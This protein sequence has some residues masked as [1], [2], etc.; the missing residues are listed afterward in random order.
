MSDA[1]AI[2]IIGMSCSFA[3]SPNTDAFWRTI[4]DGNAHFREVPANR[5]DHSTFYSPNPRHGDMTYARKLAFL[6]DIR[7]FAP[8][9][10]GIPPKRAHLMDPQ[11]RLFLDQTRQA[12]DD[13]GYGIRALPRSTGV[14]VGASVSEY[15]D[16]IVSRLR[17]R[18]ILGGQWGHKPALSEISVSEVVQDIAAMQQ[19]SMI[20]GLLNMIACNVSEAFDLQGPA[21]V[22]D[23]ACSSSLVALQEAVLHL[24]ERICDAAIVGGVHSICSPDMMV[25]FSKIGALSRH[26]ICRPFDSAADGF[27]L[28]E[29]VGAVILKRL[30]DAVRDHDHIRAVIRG[31]GLNNDGRGDGPMTPRVDGQLGA[32]AR[33]FQDA[34]ISPET[35]SYVEA[36]GTAT[37]VGDTTEISALK[38]NR[39]ANNHHSVNCG[40]G[41]VKGNIG[42][43]LAA[44]GI[45][46]IIKA[47]L[48][49]E[50][51]QIPP[52]AGLQTPRGALQLDGSG[53]YVPS[54]L[55]PFER[56]VDSPRRIGVSSFGFGGTNVHVLLEESPEDARLLPIS[57]PDLCQLFVISA[58]TRPLLARYVDDLIVALDSTKASLFDIAFTLT[59]A[60]RREK[61]K[62]I[63]VAATRQELKDKLLNASLALHSGAKDDSIYIYS[64]EQTV[65]PKLA[66]LFAGQID[67]TPEEFRTFLF[68]FPEIR[69]RVEKLAPIDNE[70]LPG[71]IAHYLAAFTKS[72]NGTTSRLEQTPPNTPEFAVL[73]AAIQICLASY[74]AELGLEPVT[75]IGLGAGEALSAACDGKLDPKVALRTIYE[76]FCR[77]S[78]CRFQKAGN[79]GGFSLDARGPLTGTSLIRSVGNNHL[80]NEEQDDSSMSVPGQAFSHVLIAFQNSEANLLLN[81]GRG[82]HLLNQAQFSPPAH[83]YRITPVL[84]LL[85]NGN[86]LTAEFLNVL[87]QLA[88]L[89]LPINLNLLYQGAKSVSLPSAP[90]PTRVF[91]VADPKRRNEGTALTRREHQT[92]DI[93]HLKSEYPAHSSIVPTAETL[94]QAVATEC[95]V[96]N[97]TVD[98]IPTMFFHVENLTSFGAKKSV[99]SMDSTAIISPRETAGD[100][101]YSSEKESKILGRLLELVAAVSGYPMEDLKPEHRLG[102]DLGFDSLMTV[103]LE[104]SLAETFEEAALLPKTMIGGETTVKDLAHAIAE[105]VVRQ[106]VIVTRNHKQESD[107]GPVITRERF[108]KRCETRFS[109]QKYPWLADH[110]IEGKPTVPFAFLLDQAAAAAKSKGI[111]PV[112]SLSQ[113]EMF[114]SATCSRTGERALEILIRGESFSSEIR[115]NLISEQG[116]NPVMR[117]AAVTSSSVLPLLACPEGG[118]TPT[119][120]V[121]EFY[122]QRTFHGPRFYALGSVDKLGPSHITGQF[123]I[124]AIG[125]IEG[126]AL[127]ILAIDAMMQLGAFWSSVTLN[128]IGYPVG[129]KEIRILGRPRATEPIRIRGVLNNSSGD[130][131]TA[132]FDLIDCDDS[133]LVQIRELRCKLTD[134]LKSA[135]PME[136][137]QQ[138]TEVEE[139]DPSTWQIDDFPEV[140]AL[141]RRMSEVRDANLPNPY[142]SIHQAV[143]NDTSVI[144]GREY[145]N[146]S[147]YN[148][149]GLSGDP[150]VTAAAIEAVHRY[151][152]SVSASR[153]ASGEKPLH[154]E[155]ECAIS[156]FLGCEDAVVMVGGHATNVS[157][158]G[159]LFGTQD[160]VLHDSL[161]H[162][163]IISGVRLSGAK[164]RSFPHNDLNVL[165]DILRKSRR[166]A[167]RVLIAIEGVYSMDG[168]IPPL[169]EIIKLKQRYHALLLVDEAHSLG[170]LGETGRGIG[171][172]YKVS[173]KDVDLWMGTL[174]K[175]LASC[176]GYIAGSAG[177][178]RYLKYTNPGFVYSVGISPANSGAALAALR[179][180][181]CHPELVDTLRS[182]SGLFHKLSQEYGV[183]TGFSKET[184]IVPCIIGNS[185]ACLQLAHLLGERQ[186]NVQPILHPAVDE[187]LARLR[188]FL[189]AKHTPE[190]ISTTVKA[191]AEAL[192]SVERE[193]HLKE[194]EQVREF[195][196]PLR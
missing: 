124:R 63:V 192:T 46:G 47:V 123:D 186:I 119:L 191:L 59:A 100:T 193:F 39:R 156:E 178:I 52:Q 12:L 171:E 82:N 101:E 33:A 176:G 10:Y 49:L 93:A 78:S 11:Q 76:T 43:T 175:S 3:G 95:G 115:A 120:S 165:E 131:L 25:A 91:W 34:E 142:F 14:Y 42:H 151:G 35:V 168:D 114:G 51:H 41:S 136:N 30:Q 109:I 149:L 169:D 73:T 166:Y 154:R 174:S 128:R 15:K 158:I 152:T 188:F 129:A 189:T 1:R 2:A 125:R 20:G 74:L 17:A 187:R 182:R 126:V 105:L 77:S 108:E 36:H 54:S 61:E 160:M 97:T 69:S 98:V 7:S 180:L 99:D 28:G 38:Q 37:P 164:R 70:G 147:S 179:K 92:N 137:R 27:V 4:R 72:F 167:R 87:G 141:E 60:R 13:A 173:R 31:V 138:H 172:L 183:D 71:S 56:R 83:D 45:A 111:G 65:Q 86:E 184:A 79:S 9:R 121:P 81:M 110:Q 190:Q 67:C 155:L 127:D 80:F 22:L 55:K 157:V 112:L 88:S 113:I 23:A 145:I 144:N 18:Q 153:L 24:R 104:A 194:V 117:I 134:H 140:R 122:K 116:V 6:D 40:V 143:T 139:Y 5:W 185:L 102:A 146:F 8:E 162:D 150:D 21:L 84:N 103:D 196:D 50:H 132:S 29:G 161:A 130:L 90:L 159:H 177:L 181:I 16:L 106:A 68:R 26:D 89:G 94:A 44:S 118:Y 163:S 75:T 48:M 107:S 64:S 85:G 57:Q 53:F 66:L 195:I 170:V 19:Y 58:A 133:P 96:V 148:Y 32:L 62:V 135:T